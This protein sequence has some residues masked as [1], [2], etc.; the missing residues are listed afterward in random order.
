[1]S[2]PSQQQQ[3]SSSSSSGFVR[4]SPPQQLRDGGDGRPTPSAV[5]SGLIAITEDRT[6][7][8][9]GGGQDGAAA[10]AA[11]EIGG[12][13][14]SRDEA[15]SSSTATKKKVDEFVSFVSDWW[16]VRYNVI[17]IIA[18]VPKT[19]RPSSRP[20][21]MYVRPTRSSPCRLFILP[22]PISSFIIGQVYPTRRFLRRLLLEG[23]LAAVGYM[24]LP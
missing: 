20:F 23:D 18:I 4:P 8:F 15:S 6:E 24:D 22:F 12:G 9:M 1:M 10:A 17:S 2:L 5:P 19:S 14:S 3:S 16:Y 21:Y 7:Y 11:F 13:S